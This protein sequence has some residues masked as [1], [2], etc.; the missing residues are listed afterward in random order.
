MSLDGKVEFGS[1]DAVVVY[2]TYSPKDFSEEGETIRVEVSKI[3]ENLS[4][5]EE[6]NLEPVL[7]IRHD[8]TRRAIGGLRATVQPEN[9]LYREGKLT[10]NKIVHLLWHLPYNIIERK[11][12]ENEIFH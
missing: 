1:D 9:L 2:K 3:I 5:V 12:H 4:D 10:G 11:M 8:S 6:F 7:N